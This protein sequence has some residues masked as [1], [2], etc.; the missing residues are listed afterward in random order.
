MISER[1]NERLQ[2]CTISVS[3]NRRKTNVLFIYI[4]ILEMN[5]FL[6][7]WTLI[8]FNIL[9]FTKIGEIP[10]SSRIR[11]KLSSITHVAIE[12]GNEDHFNWAHFSS[13]RKEREREMENPSKDHKNRS[14]KNCFRASIF[15][16]LINV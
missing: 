14:S 6:Y 4:K 1:Q 13:C 10:L 5:G 3:T 9:K 12:F 15:L 2:L 7:F 11:T 8:L 16:I